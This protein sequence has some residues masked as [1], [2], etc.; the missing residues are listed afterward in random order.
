VKKKKFFLKKLNSPPKL[1]PER[2]EPETLRRST[3][4]RPKP[5]P[6]GQPKWVG[7]KKKL[8]FDEDIV[9]IAYDFRGAEEREEKDGNNK[10]F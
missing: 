4:P 2:I 9:S 8:M 3:L 7:E 10:G 1:A 6:S 5:I